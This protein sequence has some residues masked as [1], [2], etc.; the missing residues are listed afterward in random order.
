MHCRVTFDVLFWP[1]QLERL[2]EIA[3]VCRLSVDRDRALL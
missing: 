3:V 1:A 2:L